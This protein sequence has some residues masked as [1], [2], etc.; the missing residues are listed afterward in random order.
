MNGENVGYSNS[1]ETIIWNIDDLV[2]N[3]EGDINIYASNDNS[4]STLKITG[5]GA[6]AFSENKVLR[7]GSNNSQQRGLIQAT[8]VTF[9][10]LDTSVGWSGIYFED[11]ADGRSFIDSCII[12][13]ATDGIYSNSSSPTIRN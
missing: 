10:A 8:G 9:T 1:S 12:E 7:I 2:I 6:I 3:P 11:Y 4:F 13:N 5:S